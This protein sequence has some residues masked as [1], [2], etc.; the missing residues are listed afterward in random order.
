MSYVNNNKK[1]NKKLHVMNIITDAVYAKKI[2][3]LQN[4][5]IMYK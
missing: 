5:Q 1:I 3:V 4:I 2:I